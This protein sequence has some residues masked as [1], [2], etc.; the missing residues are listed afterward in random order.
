[1]T[2]TLGGLLARSGGTDLLALSVVRS[3][4]GYVTEVTRFERLVRRN[5]NMRSNRAAGETLRPFRFY[6]GKRAPSRRHSDERSGLT[7][8]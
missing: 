8:Y 2:L 7:R 6:C 4:T 3:S 1:M 5:G